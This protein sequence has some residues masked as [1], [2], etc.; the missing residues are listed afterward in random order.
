MMTIIVYSQQGC[1]QCKMIKMMLDKKN[2]SYEVCEDTEVMRSKGILHT[3]TL[4]VDGVRYVAKPMFDKVK[5][6]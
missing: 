6:L 4:E 2:I 1:P 5:E 3:P